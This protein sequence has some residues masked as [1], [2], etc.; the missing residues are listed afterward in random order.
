MELETLVAR[1][2][3]DGD[4]AA[5]TAVVA[6]TR[7]K[8]MAVARR[9]GAP[10]DAD[11]SVQAAY[12]S[13]L[14]R[15]T[16]PLDAPV[17]PWL[18]T[19]VIRIAY[20]RKAQQARQ[21]GLMAHLGQEDRERD[22]ATTAS[23]AERAHLVREEI[24]KLPAKY[25][26]AIVLHH[27]EGISTAETARLIGVPHATLKA[28]LQRGRK[29]LRGR[30]HPR[31]GATL[32]A[33]PWWVADRG[34]AATAAVGVGALAMKKWAAL[35]LVLAFVGIGWVVTRAA[36][37]LPPDRSARSGFEPKTR[38]KA[39]EPARAEVNSKSKVP[40]NL[41][42]DKPAAASSTSTLAKL[43]V[44]IE[45]EDGKK[46]SF[47][48]VH[49]V[50]TGAD[51]SEQEVVTERDGLAEFSGL[52]RHVTWT[53]HVRTL[54]YASYSEA[55]FFD[56][57][58][59]KVI[60]LR[61]PPKRE[62][63]VRVTD[64][65]GAAV[66]GCEIHVQHDGGFMH[67]PTDVEGRATLP[68]RGDVWTVA[69]HR[70]GSDLFRLDHGRVAPRA[71]LVEVRTPGRIRGRV[72]NPDGKALPLAMIRVERNGKFLQTDLA[73]KDGTF[74]ILVPGG[75]DPVDLAFA[76]YHFE[77]NGM[78]FIHDMAP[79][80]GRVANV[81]VGAEGVVLRT[82][83]APLD[84]MLLI[85]VR[86]EAGR[87]LPKT[88]V[89]ASIVSAWLGLHEGKT[90]AKGQLQLIGVAR[91]GFEVELTPA[92]AASVLPRRVYAPVD[93]TR[94]D[95]VLPTLEAFEARVLFRGEPLP[96]AHVSALGGGNPI[97]IPA[98]GR[99]R[100]GI[101]AHSDAPATL[102]FSS[103]SQRGLRIWTYVIRDRRQ[104]TIELSEDH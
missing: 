27:L 96:V 102:S 81:K 9:I 32:F 37:V 19:T 6:R 58:P 39:P 52:A 71:T 62:L 3:A 54:I 85:D 95:I 75:L 53:L 43:R 44:R 23:E 38:A 50:G 5:M 7:S 77:K 16:R 91:R 86:D 94:L 89:R 92:D 2:V 65:D 13:L 73:K 80:V 67:G 103:S 74:S 24:A 25:R 93:A 72:L 4:S 1:F 10:Q 30:L 40:S 56:D 60:R 79:F 36:R 69:G 70:A 64:A 49:L 12:H 35:V 59:I 14:R 18:L 78:T 11:D 8:L 101:P 17:L 31:L 100:I 26:D 33:L 87:P 46:V 51:A 20:R 21:T 29:L 98:S 90:N 76:G 28:R 61:G 42:E 34:L 88:K 104:R 15:A 41:A 97:R 82:E 22:P 57:E 55:V 48:S 68:V 84:K 63:I 45:D 83:K 66:A 99:F 47:A